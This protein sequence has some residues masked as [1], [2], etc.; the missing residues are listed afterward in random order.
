MSGA[1]AVGPH[2][3]VAQEPRACSLPTLDGGSMAR[4]FIAK[5]PLNLSGH[6]RHKVRVSRR[7]SGMRTKKSRMGLFVRTIGIARARIKTG[8][9]NLPTISPASYGTR[10]ELR[11]QDG[12]D[13]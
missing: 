10:G 3:S 11:P 12:E 6:Y 9:A 8:M 2:P 4:Y 13:R 1:F 7:P 5:C